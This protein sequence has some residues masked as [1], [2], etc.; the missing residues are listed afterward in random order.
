[1][2]ASSA[3]ASPIASTPP[4]DDPATVA[5]FG[6][7]GSG[8]ETLIS[9]LNK[10]PY[11]RAADGM[12]F[13]FLARLGDEDSPAPIAVVLYDPTNPK[14]NIAAHIQAA[15]H[16]AASVCVV[17][18]KIDLVPSDFSD[19]H[20]ASLQ[21]APWMGYNFQLDC[22]DVSLTTGDGFDA[23]LTYLMDCIHPPSYRRETFGQKLT[24]LQD[25]ILDWIATWFA[26]PAGQ[27]TSDVS[28]ELSEIES[29]AAVYKRLQSEM[30]KAW[31][32]RLKQR[33]HVENISMSPRVHRISHSLLAKRA[34]PSEHANMDYVRQHTTIPIPRIH[35]P[36]ISPTLIMD[37]I[38]G[39]MLLECWDKL[40]FLTR[41]R[42][43]CTLRLYVKQLRSLRRPA[44]GAVDTRYV[45]G[46]LFGEDCYG[47]YDSLRRFRQFCEYVSSV[48]WQTHAIMERNAGRTPPL[49]PRPKF[50]WTPV[51]THGDLNTSN[52][53]LDRQG[54]LWILDWD[55][56]GFYPACME[57]VAM[58]HMDTNV[59][60]DDTPHSWSRYRWFIAGATTDE[61]EQFWFN[62]YSAIHRFPGTPNY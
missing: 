35:R 28:A 50:D 14:A 1:M 4:S 32:T 49:L 3:V 55:F 41:F 51:F 58:W 18:T 54:A 61:E 43:A 24:R 27:V 5:V 53:L 60:P 29:D 59:H 38:E 47:P 16:S 42:I 23:L 10:R 39:E 46:L 26:L 12:S 17:Q 22:F 62:F 7:P 44:P 25:A 37:L 19:A 52:V 36:D 57:S 21:V 6:D 33:L 45:S 13:M 48:G 11:T 8:R 20:L 9:L 34:Q 31:A 56:A 40:G 2:K 15:Q 30:D